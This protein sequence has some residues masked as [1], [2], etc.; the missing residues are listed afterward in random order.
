MAGNTSSMA[1]EQEDR[2]PWV[3]K[4]SKLKDAVAGEEDAGC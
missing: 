3:L 4:T 1:L 2:P